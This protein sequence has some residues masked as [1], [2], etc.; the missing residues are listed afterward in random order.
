[1]ALPLVA[2]PLGLTYGHFQSCCAQPGCPTLRNTQTLTTV[3]PVV[4]LCP[5]PPWVCPCVHCV[6]GFIKRQQGHGG[7]ES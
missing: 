5:I 7:Q 4:T 1:M 6:L 3:P 2:S